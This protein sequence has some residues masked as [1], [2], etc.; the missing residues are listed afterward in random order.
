[1]LLITHGSKYI[2]SFYHEVRL[3]TNFL[4]SATGKEVQQSVKAY[5]RDEK[6]QRQDQERNAFQT[7]KPLNNYATI[8]PNHTITMLPYLFVAV[9]ITC[10]GKMFNT[11]FF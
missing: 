7:A 5:R 4:I 3:R 1:M 11:F 2:N 9:T 8:S 6:E 10:V